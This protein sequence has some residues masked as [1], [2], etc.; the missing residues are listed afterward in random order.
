MGVL[1]YG[2]DDAIA[3]LQ[4]FPVM[5]IIVI[6]LRAIDVLLGRSGN[7]LEE[8]VHPMRRGG[9]QKNPENSGNAQV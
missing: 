6:M 8:M 4:R 3:L 1:R 2:Q 7:L 9:D 5:M